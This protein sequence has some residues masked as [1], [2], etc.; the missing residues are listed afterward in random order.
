MSEQQVYGTKMKYLWCRQ[1][2]DREG[3]RPGPQVC[4]T[5]GHTNSGAA[6]V[7]RER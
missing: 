6:S 4:P 7:Q 2:V 3:E 5:P 1:K